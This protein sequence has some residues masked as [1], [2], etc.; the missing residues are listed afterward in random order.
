MSLRHL[1]LHLSSHY[2]ISDASVTLYLT[3]AVSPIALHSSA[4][5]LRLGVPESHEAYSVAVSQIHFCGG[6]S[7]VAPIMNC[8]P[9]STRAS[10]HRCS[11]LMLALL[12]SHPHTAFLAHLRCLPLMLKLLL[13]RSH[14]FPLTLALL[15]SG[16]ASAC[17]MPAFT[18]P[19]LCLHSLCLRSLCLHSLCIHSACARPAFTLHSLCLR[20]ACIHSACALRHPGGAR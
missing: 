7:C 10:L 6:A 14:C 18:L 15:S 12:C 13:S 3:S 2:N 5:S 19:A 20:S 1:R 9:A 4:P 8:S 17:A 11:A 16:A